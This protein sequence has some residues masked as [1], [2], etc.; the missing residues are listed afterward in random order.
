MMKKIPDTEKELREAFAVFDSDSDGTT[1]RTELKRIMLKFGQTL[2]D[3]ELDAV[4]A[5]VD[6]D[7]DGV[8]SFEEFK[9]VMNA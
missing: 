6:D 9:L 5:E 7:G 8:I 3:Q 4:M 1:S 2:T